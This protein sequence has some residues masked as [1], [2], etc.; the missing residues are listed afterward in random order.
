MGTLGPDLP[1]DWLTRVLEPR[2]ASGVWVNETLARAMVQRFISEMRASSAALA[3]R[4]PVI[5]TTKRAAAFR[6]LCR[7]FEATIP[8]ELLISV[9]SAGDRSGKSKDAV[10][11]YGFWEVHAG[12]RRLSACCLSIRARNLEAVGAPM[13]IVTDHALQRLFERLRT[14]ERLTVVREMS[15]AVATLAE[16]MQLLFSTHISP[17]LLPTPSGAF[18]VRQV[19]VRA[20][21]VPFSAV[22]WASDTRMDDAPVKLSAVLAARAENGIATEFDGQWLVLSPSRAAKLH[23]TPGRRYRDLLRAFRASGSPG[24]PCAPSPDP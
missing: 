2:P 8:P 18:V 15:P 5:R 10:R 24:D 22:T 12:T 13:L 19:S 9:D 7:H 17:F 1:C 16:Y 3:A 6:A 14:M 20:Q 23:G 21:D 11:T 4:E